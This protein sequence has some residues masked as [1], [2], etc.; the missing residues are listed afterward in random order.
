VKKIHINF[1]FIESQ[2]Y[3]SYVIFK[4]FIFFLF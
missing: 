1:I 4:W 3:I 2:F